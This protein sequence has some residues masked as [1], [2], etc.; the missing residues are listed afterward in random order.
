[1]ESIKKILEMRENQLLQIK[2]KKEKA[3]ENAPEG[4]LRICA[5]GKRVQFYQRTDPKDF[6]GVYIRENEYGL[7]KKLAQKDYDKKV[8]RVVNKELKAIEKCMADYPEFVAEQ[9]YGRQHKTR[10]EIVWPIEET[11]QQCVQRW[12]NVSYEKKGFREDMPELY[13]AKEE[14]VRSKSEIIIADLLNNK[15]IPYRY[16]CPIILKGFG[17]V[18]PDFTVLNVRL[19][20][21]MYWE[22]LGMM[23]DPEYVEKALH[24]ISLYEQN[25]IF[26]GD[27]LILTYEIKAIPINQKHVAT[28]IQ[29]YLL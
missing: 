11:E 7:A 25:G 16:E 13:T 4:S 9:V 14:R 1:M 20:K 19:R 29:H 2:S 18:Y 15:G 8:L 24:K 3:I 12:Q 28:I 27:K 5:N 23:D 26:V 6:N 10:Q 17:I 22:H 21:E